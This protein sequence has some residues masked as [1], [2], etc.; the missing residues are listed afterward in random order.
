VAKTYQLLKLLWALMRTGKAAL[1]D[2]ASFEKLDLPAVRR[3][4]GS[5]KTAAPDALE[6]RVAEAEQ[7]IADMGA[8]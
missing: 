2:G 7:T 3:V 8:S 6:Q 1:K 5:V 4:F